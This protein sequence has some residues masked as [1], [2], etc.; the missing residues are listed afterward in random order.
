MNDVGAVADT[1]DVPPCATCGRRNPLDARFCGG[2][3]SPVGASMEAQAAHEAD[4][5]VGRVVADRY[6]LRRLL[7]RGGMGVVYEVEHVHI[8]KVMAMK[9]L[10]GELARDKN[11]QKRFQREAEA[12]S[13]LSHP[14]TVQVFD[15]G[16]SEGMM[17]L[18]MEYLEGRDLGQVIR[19]EG[20]LE[21][22][23]AARIVAQV[24]AS[25]AEAHVQGIVHRDL[26]PEN[27]MI[28][29]E[30][31]GRAE[32]AKVLDFGLAKLRD[33]SGG[34]TVT[35]A[36]AIVGT[37]YY[38]PPEQIRG[39]D[40][41]ARGDVYAI[42]AMLYK[43][44]TGVP[45]FMANTPMG[46][47]TKHLTEE[48][49]P[50]SSRVRGK[51]LPLEADAI[52]GRA[53][54][55]NPD[56]RYGSA[57]ELRRELLGYLAAI[58]QA[59]SDPSMT[60]MP[61]GPSVG[62]PTAVATRRDVDNYEKRL[63]RRGIFTYLFVALL[64]GGAAAGGFFAWKKW[65]DT[66][67]V[68][69]AEREPNDAPE[70]ALPLPPGVEVTGLLGKRQD[71][72]VGD[73]DLWL[74][75]NPG[76]ERRM[77]RVELG[78]LPNVDVVLDVYRRGQSNPLVSVDSGGRRVGERLPA[79]PFPPGDLLLRV[80]ERW[81]TGELP[82]ENVSDTYTLRWELVD[83][84]PGDEV[85]VN[86]SFELANVLPLGAEVRGFI[87]W[88]GD[89]DV[90]CAAEDA[91]PVDVVLEGVSMVDLYLK[92]GDRGGVGFKRIDEHG[93]GEGERAA[94]D[95]VE[96]GRTCVEIG[97]VEEEPRRPNGEVV[98]VEPRRANGEV[99]WTLRVTPQGSP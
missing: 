38:M 65:S 63:R 16:R 31:E 78:A 75:T 25:V 53:M 19:D 14:N 49:V 56:S 18:V 81:I 33:H 43:A 79:F 29:P 15:F 23:R 5:L 86:D 48:L 50:P 88:A 66:P 24:C 89:V 54:Q 9:L 4:P 85:E 59:V 42:G 77:L 22:G 82:T 6:R 17:Y 97:V 44:C 30:R 2:C 55:K 69:T 41:D 28:L 32:V 37:P 90:F 57:D 73:V 76:P 71:E 96:R 26:K 46:V 74:V 64:V 80:R 99:A 45:P 68:P 60:S 67:V 52:I 84:T 10:H 27:V 8:G 62:A 3:G 34:M 93:V 12:A 70:Q 83:E 61:V 72:T 40:V 91:G 1:L 7:G 47:L 35:R 58:G 94:L 92:V 20:A 11:T 95:S 87:A 36:G 51:P 39:E 13:R 98:L 21:F